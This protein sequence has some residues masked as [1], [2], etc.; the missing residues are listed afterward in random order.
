MMFYYLSA[1]DVGFGR[2]YWQ[3]TTVDFASAP[4]PTGSWDV[5]TLTILAKWAK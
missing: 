5:T 4:T 2:R 1:V 3:S